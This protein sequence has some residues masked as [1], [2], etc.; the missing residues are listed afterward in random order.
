MGENAI[1]RL[2]ELSVL[3]A[4]WNVEDQKILTAK[5]TKPAAKD[6]KKLSLTKE[7]RCS[8]GGSVLICPSCF[9]LLE[10]RLRLLS[11]QP[12]I[13]HLRPYVIGEG[14]FVS[15]QRLAGKVPTCERNYKSGSCSCGVGN[16]SSMCCL[17]SSNADDT[18]LR[19]VLA[20]SA[21]DSISP[22]FSKQ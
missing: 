5:Y 13:N 2:G 11:V 22:S 16:R 7:G 14:R 12:R 21:V 3:G 4:A 1:G 9:L 20:S 8:N 15:F 6:A 18:R 19:S 17:I 10:S